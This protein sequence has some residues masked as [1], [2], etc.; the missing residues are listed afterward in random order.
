ME[1]TQEDTDTADSCR[2]AF[3]N[4]EGVKDAIFTGLFVLHQGF[5]WTLV[6]LVRNDGSSGKP[7]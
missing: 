5:L 2:D 3:S 7:I 4:F 1:S 6:F